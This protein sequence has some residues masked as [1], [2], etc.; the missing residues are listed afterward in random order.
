MNQH[1]KP[2]MLPDLGLYYQSLGHLT[3]GVA[4]EAFENLR[5]ENNFPSRDEF[6]L[7]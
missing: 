1:H 7:I 2:E 6:N 5:P 4:I 3:A